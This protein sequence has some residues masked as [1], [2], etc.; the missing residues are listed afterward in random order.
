MKKIDEIKGEVSGY[1][2]II[3]NIIIFIMVTIF[4]VQNIHF[5]YD[6][7]IFFILVG[8]SAGCRETYLEYRKKQIMEDCN[9]ESNS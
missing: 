3:I 6:L 8:I 5:K 2:A 4:T 7:F 1:V 9:N